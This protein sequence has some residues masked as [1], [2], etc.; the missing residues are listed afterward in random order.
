MSVYI[1]PDAATLQS[2]GCSWQLLP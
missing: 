2:A 1:Y